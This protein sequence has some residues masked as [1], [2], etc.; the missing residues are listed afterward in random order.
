MEILARLKNVVQTWKFYEEQIFWILARLSTFFG[1]ILVF[2][3]GSH[4]FGLIL[5]LV[6][7]DILLGNEVPNC[8]AV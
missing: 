8:L 5:T 1:Y 6:I 2:S 4:N 7:I 3:F